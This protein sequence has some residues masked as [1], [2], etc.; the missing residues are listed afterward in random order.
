VSRSD[1]IVWVAIPYAAIAVFVVGHVLRYRRDQYNWGARSSQLLESRWLRIGSVVFHYG[2]LGAIGGHVVGILIPHSVT[3]SLGISEDTYHVVAAAGGVAAGG[4]AVAGFLILVYR[5]ARFPRVRAVT[6]RM[7]VVVFALLAFGLVTGMVATLWGT[8]GEEVR[9][10]ETVAP[11]FRG[12]LT[13]DPKPELMS[14]ADAPP[15]IFQLHVTGLWLLFAAWP[16]SRLVHA[17]S[18]PVDF[19]RRSPILYR[20]RAGAHR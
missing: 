19:F 7:D 1:L 9:Y 5:R 12:L 17:W 6:T 14:G 16:F 8:L 10:R 11:W 18:I 2:A 3:S 20:K 4:A 13:L 15:F